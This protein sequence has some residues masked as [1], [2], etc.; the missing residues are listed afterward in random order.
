MT[1]EAERSVGRAS[2]PEMLWSS[3]QNF[4]NRFVDDIFLGDFIYR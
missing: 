2:L 3:K 4:A 1:S